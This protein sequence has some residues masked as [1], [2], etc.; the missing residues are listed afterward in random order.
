MCTSAGSLLKHVKQLLFIFE[1]VCVCV[2]VSKSVNKNM[3]RS[4][5]P[6]LLLV[7]I[8]FKYISAELP[9]IVR[10]VARPCRFF[11][12]WNSKNNGDEFYICSSPPPLK[13]ITF[14][15]EH[16]KI[17]FQFFASNIDYNECTARLMR[18]FLQN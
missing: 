13:Y 10:A 3:L 4:L 17:K 8:Y 14:L 11:L 1:P 6:L 15:C 2:C 16:I 5:L 9:Q 12:K 7:L 18:Q